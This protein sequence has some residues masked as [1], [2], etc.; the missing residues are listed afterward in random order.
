MKPPAFAYHAPRSLEAGLDLLA[1]LG[2][3]A[4]VLAGG[5]SLVPML[6]MRLVAPAALVDIRHLDDLDRVE[7]ADGVVRVGARVTHTRLERDDDVAAALPLLREALRLVA[8]PVIRNRGTSVGSVVH[9]DPAGELPAVV[10]L[11]DATLEL[12][13]LAGTRTVSGADVFAGPLE[14]ALRPG[15]L[16]TAVT[17]PRLESGTGTAIEELARRHGDYALAGV[18]VRVD[19][20]TD[21]HVSGASAAFFGVGGMPHPIDLTGPLRGQPAD[22]LDVTDA[23]GAARAR[24]DPDDDIHATA[25]YRRHLAG[26]LLERA[27]QRAARQAAARPEVLT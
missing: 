19:L 2:A 5:Q 11:L 21:R 1:D 23:V 26:V 20:D 4:K 8:H 17:F 15:E 13:S 10:A 6:N 25:S 9:A 12:T 14:C 22:T 7:V 3:D 18:A 24:L 27:L 16:A